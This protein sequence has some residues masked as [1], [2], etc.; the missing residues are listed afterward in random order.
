MT[1]DRHEHGHTLATA[2][3]DRPMG[4]LA[5]AADGLLV[6]YQKKI[7]PLF[8]PSCRF[9]P[10][11]SSYARRA[12]ATEPLWRAIALT[13]WRLLRCQPLCAGGD[14]PVPADRDP[15]PRGGPRSTTS[16]A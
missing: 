15:S 8:A 3:S 10:S 7:S 4:W 9:H 11:C 5:R 16:M 2:S 14:D 6:V 1:L 13:T 12:L